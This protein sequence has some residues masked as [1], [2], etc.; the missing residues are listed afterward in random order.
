MTDQWLPCRQLPYPLRKSSVLLS[1]FHTVA[2]RK[3][4]GW[5]DSLLP[6]GGGGPQKGWPQWTPV[7]IHRL[8][9]SAVKIHFC[10]LHLSEWTQGF[11]TKG[12]L[13]TSPPFWVNMGVLLLCSWIIGDWKV[14]DVHMYMSSCRLVGFLWTEEQTLMSFGNQRSFS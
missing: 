5:C 6:R 4:R 2:D 14:V 12:P 7:L 8:F 9:P 11:W 10:G 13:E 3:P 1:G